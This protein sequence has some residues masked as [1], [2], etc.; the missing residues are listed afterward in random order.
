[1]TNHT[2]SITAQAVW[3]AFN[4][5]AERVGVF[6]DYGDALAAFTRALADQVAPEQK[7]WN[8]TSETGVARHSLRRQILD[9]A[10][11]LEGQQ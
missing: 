3:Q 8:R 10:A 5:V 6:E 4:D 2:L 9:I 11:E 7:P 1:M